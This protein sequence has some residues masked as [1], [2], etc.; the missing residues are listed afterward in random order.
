MEGSAFAMSPNLDNQSTN[1]LLL[2]FNWEGNIMPSRQFST[3]RNLL[4]DGDVVCYR[5]DKN[6]SSYMISSEVGIGE[7]NRGKTNEKK[8]KDCGDGHIY[9]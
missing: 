8:Y 3:Y 5:N 2:K 7:R 1:Y 6:E 4:Y 9:T